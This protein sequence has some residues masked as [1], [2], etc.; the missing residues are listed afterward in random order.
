[1]A[2][3]KTNAKVNN[4]LLK[5]VKDAAGKVKSE[6][7]S[8]LVQK[9]EKQ[10]L[11]KLSKE[12]VSELEQI[13]NQSEDV[14]PEAKNLVKALSQAVN[15]G[16]E[17]VQVIA[18][19][20]ALSD[21]Q[22]GL[23]QGVGTK[24]A[25]N[26]ATQR[27]YQQAVEAGADEAEAKEA[28][29]KAR[30]SILEQVVETA[31]LEEVN[32]I[33]A[34][35]VDFGAAFSAENTES[36][37]LGGQGQQAQQGGSEA[38]EAASA[39]EAEATQSIAPASESEA[40]QAAQQSSQSEAAGPAAAESIQAGEATGG[41]APTAEASSAGTAQAQ[42]SESAGSPVGTEASAPAAGDGQGGGS[43][44]GPAPQ[45]SQVSG[46]NFGGGVDST[47]GAGA[48]AGGLVS[49]GADAPAVVSA[50]AGIDSGFGGGGDDLLSVSDVN[51]L[52]SPV[53][54]SGGGFGDSAAEQAL[55]ASDAG[56]FNS[57]TLGATGSADDPGNSTVSF[58]AGT[59]VVTQSLGGGT[60]GV[61][62]SNL[63][64]SFVAQE[65]SLDGTLGTQENEL[66]Q[67]Q[68]QQEAGDLTQV[69]GG[70][71]EGE[72]P[73]DIVDGTQVVA[74]QTESAEVVFVEIPP[75]S[76]N[77][78]EIQVLEDPSGEFAIFTFEITKGFIGNT[79]S[80]SWSVDGNLPEEIKE[81]L[82]K[83]TV[84]MSATQLT[85]IVE[86]R[87]PA[88][89]MSF[90]EQFTISL[91]AN[92][93]QTFI[94]GDAE[95]TLR[96]FQADAQV[97]IAAQ[98]GIVRETEEGSET[99][100]EFLVTR[101]RMG[102]ET[103]LDWS[104]DDVEGNNLTAEDFVGGEIPSGV[105]TF[106]R[107]LTQDTIRIVVQ[108]DRDVEPDKLL[109][110]NLG[111]PGELIEVLT[112][113]AES[114]IFNDDTDWSIVLTSERSQSEGHSGQTE[115]TFEVHRE[116]FVGE[117]ASVDFE[118]TGVGDVQIQASDIVGGVLPS[119]TLEF[120]ANETVKTITVPIQGD[121][122]IEA[123][124]KF[125]IEIKNVQGSGGQDIVLASQE[126]TVENDDIT[127][128][129]DALSNGV[130]ESRSDTSRIIQWEIS[131]NGSDAAGEVSWALKP[132]N[133]DLS[134]VG[135]V[136]PT[137][138][139]TF[140]AGES[141]KIVSI[142]LQGDE[143]IE[144]DKTYTL[145]LSNPGIN[146]VIDVSA[147]EASN[148]VRNDDIGFN[149]L[150]VKNTEFEG[151]GGE[152]NTLSYK[153]VRSF[154]VDQ[155]GSVDYILEFSGTRTA[156]SLDFGNGQNFDMPSGTV[157]FAAGET[158]K[159]ITINLSGDNTPGPDEAFKIRLLN[160][161]NNGRILI[162]SQDG[163][164]QNDDSLIQFTA[165][166]TSLAE[167]NETVNK[168]VLTFTR[169][170][171]L[172]KAVS[173][174]FQISGTGESLAN[175]TDF[176]SGQFPS[177][178]VSFATGE[179]NKTVEIALGND[180]QYEG[181]EFFKINFSNPV[182]AEVLG[183]G[184]V[185]SVNPDDSVVSISA[186]NAILSEGGTTGKTHQ[187]L[188]SRF[189]N[190]D[191]EITLN[192]TVKAADNSSA[193][194]ADFGGTL[195]S[196]TITLAANEANKVLEITP[197]ADFALEENE[198][199]V[200][201]ITSSHPG[202]SIL[203]S[204]ASGVIMNDESG[205]VI[206]DVSLTSTEGDTGN[207]NFEFKVTRSGSVSG[208]GTV[209]WE[210]IPG[211]TNPVDANDFNGSTLPS[212]T[213]NF[214]Q[215]ELTKT[216]AIAVAGD[217][218]NEA[219]ENFKLVLKNPSTGSVLLTSEVAGVIQNDDVRVS[220]AADQASKLEGQSG[221]TS[222][223]FT[224]TRE[225][226]LTGT[227][228]VNYVVSGNGTNQAEATDFDGNTF[229]SGTVSFAAGETSK[230]I[231]VNISGDST[232][233]NNEGFQVTLN[234]PSVG[235]ELGT[236]VA[237]TTITDDDDQLSLSAQTAT[238]SETDA[239]G[240]TLTYVVN[241]TGPTN[242]VTTVD[243]AVSGNGANPVDGA[244][245]IGGTLPSG[246]LTFNEGETSKTITLNLAGDN[247]VEQNEG[248]K[249]TLSNPS[250]GTS[251]DT[252]ELTGTV[253][254]DDSGLSVAAT[255]TDLVEGSG[256]N[257]N[258]VFTIT[259]S[260][261]LD[262]SNTVDWSLEHQNTDNSDFVATTGQVTFAAGE[263]TKTVNL[264]VVGDTT[265][266]AN[267]DF[268][269]KVNGGTANDQLIQGSV[270]NNTIVSDDAGL[271]IAAVVTS[272]A[273]GKAGDTSQIEFTVTR[274][275]NTTSTASANWA[276]SGDVN[277]ADFGGTLPS[278][279]VSFA[280]G[281]TS[282]TITLS[283]KGDNT[284]ENNER[285]DV[286]LSNPNSGTYIT[287]ATASTTVTN[288]DSQVS[289]SNPTLTVTE[290]NTGTQ[291]L[292]YTV[293]RAG[294]TSK[295][296]TVGWKA[297]ASG[298][299]PVDV[300]DFANGQ[301]GN[302]NNSGLPSGT[303]SFAAGETSKTFSLQVAGENKV[304]E[305]E[306]FQIQFY[307][308]GDNT[309][310]TLAANTVTITNDDPGVSI[311]AVNATKSEGDSGTT[312]V[313]F[314]VIRKGDL[315]Q[316][317][318]VD[319]AVSG[320]VNAADFVGALPSGKLTFAANET[321]KTLELNMQGDTAVE[322]NENLTVT[323]SNA[324]VQGTA[325]QVAVPVATATTSILNEDESFSVSVDQANLAEGNADQKTLTYTVTRSGDTTKAV[326][327]NYAVSSDNGGDN[328][329]VS[330]T[331][332]SG[333]LS[334]AAGETSK[335]V[336]VNVLGDTTV[337]NNENLKL[338]LS[339]PS[340]G[341]LGTAEV[342]SVITND[343]VSFG[344]TANA[345]SA[346]EGHS[347]NTPFTF[348]VTRTGVSTGTG[349]VNYAVAA[350][351]NLTA[352]D[353][354]GNTLPSGTINFADGET[355]KTLTINVS[356]DTA[357]ESNESFVVSL[358]NPSTGTIES[359][360][361]TATSTITS[362]DD[363]VAVSVNSSSITEGQSGTQNLVYTVTRT[364]STSSTS[365]VDY[366]VTGID[367]ADVSAGTNLTGTL[368]FSAGETT[369]TVTIPLKGD[370]TVETDET[371]V[372]TLSNPSTGTGITTATANTVISNDDASFAVTALLADKAEGNSG[373]V[374]YTF[375]ITRSGF[376]SQS[377]TVQ[378]RITGIGSNPANA[379]D[380][381]TTDAL[382]DNGGLPSGTLTFAS[383]E[384]SK[385]LTINV[386]AESVKEQNEDFRVSL[387]NPSSGSVIGTATADGQIDNDDA[388]LN[389]AATTITRAEVDSS[390]TDNFV[391]TVNRT[392]NTSQSSTVNWNLSN[393]TGFSTNTT[394]GDLVNVVADNTVV[395][396]SGTLT[397][398]S[399]QTSKTIT[400]KVRGDN[401]V[402]S[403]EAFN[404]VLSGASA[405]TSLG[406]SSSATG[407]MTNDDTYLDFSSTVSKA[408]GLSGTT[409]FVYTVTRS[410]NLDR[411]T[412][413]NY[414]ITGYDPAGSSEDAASSSD[415][416]GG[417]PSGSVS[418]AA[419]ETTKTI[420]LNV[421]GDATVE[422][423]EWFQFNLSSIVGAENNE[424]NTSS[425]VRG[426]IKR[427]EA[428]LDILD[429]QVTAV[430]NSS[431]L[432]YQNEGD[433]GSTNKVMVFAVK[434]TVSTSGT[435][436]VQWRVTDTGGTAEA[437]ANDFAAGQDSLADNSGLP[438]G[439][440]TFADGE[441]YAYISV[442]VKADDNGEDNETFD[443]T[444]S[445]AS[446]G[447]TI[448]DTLLNQA[449]ILNDDPLF[450]VQ[451]TT[452]YVNEGN[453][454]GT[455]TYTFTA[456]RTGDTKGAATVDWV[457]N[458]P[459]TETT[460]ESLTT[461][462]AWY[463]LE[464]ADFAAGLV[465]SGTL[466]FADGESSKTVTFSVKA[467]ELVESYIESG[468]ITLSN[469]VTGTGSDPV[470]VSQLHPTTT[471]S[472]VD[473]EPD[474]TVVVTAETGQLEGT[475][476]TTNVTFTLTRTDIAGRAGNLTYPSTFY[477][478][479]SINNELDG[480]TSGYITIAAGQTTA[481]LDVGIVEDDDIE[482][483]LNFTMY[484]SETT[485]N[486]GSG[487]AQLVGTDSFS[488]FNVAVN[489]TVVD[490]DIR[491]WASNTSVVE[492][493]TGT[494][495]L[496]FTVTRRGYSGTAVSFNYN[497]D[498]AGSNTTETSDFVTRSGTLTL[499][500]NETSKTFVL[501]T[502]TTNTTKEG[503]ETFEIDLSNP[504][505]GA[506]FHQSSNTTG[507][508]TATFTG[509]IEDDDTPYHVNSTGGSAKAESDTGQTSVFSF[510]ISRDTGGDDDA[511]TI[512]WRVAGNGTHQANAA[513]FSTSDALGDNGGLPS[514]TVSFAAGEYSKTVNIS[515]K[516]DVSAENSEGF[517]MVISN[518]SSG[519][520]GT[521]Q[522]TATIT[523]DDTG[524]SI[525]D[526]TAVTEGNS[527]TK[528]ITF[529]VTRSG[530]LTPT[531]TM[532]YGVT[533]VSTDANDF[534]GS[535]TGS[536]SFS[537]GQS[538]KT[539]TIKAKGD[540]TVENNETFKVTLSSL[541]NVDEAID[542]EAVGTINNDD[543]NFSIAA[544]SAN[545]TENSGT[546]HTFTI[547][548]D[549]DTVQTQTVRWTV[550]GDQVNAADFGGSLP[551]NTVT[552]NPGELTKTVTIN[553]S[554]DTSGESDENFTVTLTDPGTSTGV[555]ISANNTASGKIINDD[556]SAVVAIANTNITEGDANSTFN[557]TV[558]RSG[559][560]S[561]TGS[562]QWKLSEVSGTVN[563]ADF[564]AG[565]D[566]LGANGGLP[567]GTVNW[568]DGEGVKTI[569][570]QIAGDKVVEEAD[571]FRITLSNPTSVDI[572]TS[573]ADATI[574]KEDSSIALVANDSTKAEGDSGTTNLTFTITRTGDLTN[575]AT[576]DYAI[577]PG[578]GVDAADFVGSSIP[579]GTVTLPAGQA[580]TTLTVPISGDVLVEGNETFTVTLSNASA[581]VGISDATEVGTITNEDIDFVVSGPA[582]NNLLEKDTGETTD[583]VF[584][585]TRSGDTSGSQTVNWAAAGNGSN[586][587][588]N[589]ELVS[590][591]DS[592]VF[593]A[594][595]TSKQVTVSVKGDLEGET[596]EGFR[597]SITAPNGTTA[598]TNHAD[599]TVKEDEAVLV[600]AS[601]QT[602]VNEGAVGSL[603]TLTY[604]VTRSG[605]TDSAVSANYAVTTNGLT[606]TE[607]END[608]IPSGT[609]NFASGETSKTITVK[610]KGDSNVETTE[611]LTLT[612]SNPS[613]GAVI[614]TASVST[615]LINDDIDWTVAAAG[616][617]ATIA[618]GD[619][620]TT[621]FTATI[622]RSG[623]V[624]QAASIDY[625]VTPQ[626]A[627]PVVVADFA[628]GA[629]PSG[630]VNFAS[631]ET[632]KTVTFDI[633]TDSIREEDEGFTLT[634]SNPTG[635]G[636]N[637]LATASTNFTI[638]N[639]DDVMSIASSQTNFIEGDSG[640]QEL[641]FTVTRSG[642][643]S[644]NSSVKWRM[645]SSS[646]T[647]SSD[648]NIT[649]GTLNFT[650]GETSKNVTIQV[651]GDLDV[652]A[653]ESYS[654]ELHDPGIGSTVSSSNGSISGQITNQD[655]DLTPSSTNLSVHEGDTTGGTFSFVV[656]RTGDTSGATTVDYKL[657]NSTTTTDDFA[658]GQDA[659]GTNNGLPSGTVSFAAGETAK[660]ISV[661]FSP[662][663]VVEADESY[664]VTLSNPSG[665]A[666]INNGTLNATLKNDDDTLAIA[667]VNASKAEGEA[668][669]VT[670]YEFKVDRGSSSVGEATVN[671]T[672]TGSSE[673]PLDVSRLVAATGTLTFADGESSKVLNI[674]LN[675]D[676]AGAYDQ[677]FTVTLSDPSFGSTI[678]TVS[679]VGTVVN[680]DPVLTVA[681]ANPT[682]VEGDTGGFITYTITRS[683]DSTGTS[684]V[685]F[686]VGGSGENAASEGDFGGEFPSGNITFAPGETT[687][688]IAIPINLDSSG[689]FDE[690]FAFTL[691]GAEGADVLGE[692]AQV[693]L[694]NDDTALAIQSTAVEQF[695]GNGNT[696]EF[697]YTVTR[698]G[699]LT[700]TSTVDWNV[701]GDGTFQVS[702]ND[703]VNDTIPSGSL[704]FAPDETSKTITF[705][706]KTDAI[707]GADEGFKVKLSNASG[708][709]LIAAEA[710]GKIKNDD[711]EIFVS[712]ENAT[713]T[714]GDTESVDYVFK[715]ARTGYLDAA[716]SVD[717][718]LEGYGESH[719][720]AADFRSEGFP[721]G[722]V[723]FAAG[724]SEKLVTVK[725][726]GDEVGENNEQFR[727]VL[728]S[729]SENAV[730][731]ESAAWVAATITNDDQGVFFSGEDQRQDEGTTENQAFTFQLHR[732]GNTNEAVTVDWAV[733][734]TGDKAASADDFVSTSG[735]LSFAAGE[736]T[737][738]LTIHSKAD[739]TVE[740]DEH[741]KVVLT[742]EGVNFPVS[743]VV[744]V[745]LDDDTGISVQAV[746]DTVQEDSGT[747]SFEIS[748]TG[749]TTE[750]LDVNYAVTGSGKSPIETN[751]LTTQVA[752]NGS[753]TF[754][755]GES[756]KTVTLNINDDSL[757]EQAEAIQMKISN[758]SGVRVLGETATVTLNDNDSAGDGND[759][760]Y[761]DAD[762]QT[763][764]GGAGNDTIVSEGGSDTL[765]G[766]AGN[767]TFVFNSPNE[768]VD[769]I[770]DFVKGQDKIKY[771]AAA[772]QN[773]Q[774]QA[775]ANQTE[776]T[777]L[778]TA[779]NSLAAKADSD[780]YT[781]DTSANQFSHE[782]GSNGHL[783]ELEAAFTNGEHTGAAFIAVSDGSATQLYFDADTNAGT[784]GTGLVHVAEVQNLTDANDIDTT[785]FE[786]SGN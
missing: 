204:Q 438:S 338:T 254:N 7:A 248:L 6:A 668:G 148:L 593:A 271:A 183:D 471:V 232:K 447:T 140:A 541:T 199:Y 736:L 582:T 358:S 753:V 167:G 669:E 210:L 641:T 467:D 656:T 433:A 567:S 740:E 37:L 351:G 175:A 400:V 457:L 688:T 507:S 727:M 501:S 565:Q 260:G 521:S 235:V 188:V 536:L 24:Q 4:N 428:N 258:H 135:G 556:A 130:V 280:A 569:S 163:T 689:E 355:T 353:F 38:A 418:F 772:F 162:D 763:L 251:L 75:T 671:W 628:G 178:S 266:E 15:N 750:S 219:N 744:G 332:P 157:Q 97:S 62:N 192:Y 324:V 230:S 672:V 720:D 99:V 314:N 604:T 597:F 731:K 533:H 739:N 756:T 468:T 734:G 152:L 757:V 783:D 401:T 664:T 632:S 408:E 479:R 322:A 14:Q 449:Q 583:F 645:A 27:A 601:S 419:G 746:T 434:R 581:N 566:A 472:V 420:T 590:T 494:T 655:I 124:E 416:V 631:G 571:T 107:G 330:G 310:T 21:F 390:Q 657:A 381:S 92:D 436:T 491:L 754:A 275:G 594:G 559:N 461:T 774:I 439:T 520:I 81:N 23:Q 16:V 279:T 392:G 524:I 136:L 225:G 101:D 574:L 532:N 61:N 111:N 620:S 201:E 128:R 775:I 343:D 367:A 527:G 766:G 647:D 470:F 356:G 397:F 383:G 52:I 211:D 478:N 427:D 607:F 303:L 508:T 340:E 506:L 399:G 239:A 481:T 184:T 670:N 591:A 611:S 45:S 66:G 215:G 229:P 185:F 713:Q 182:G 112:P 708:A 104:L 331:L 686:N 679:A 36:N 335:T 683:G 216:L 47:T 290:G 49:N 187:F 291:T 543:S 83:D 738:Q 748:R 76:V 663:G 246:T 65:V 621:T 51:E 257:S 710:T 519:K 460:N 730:I 426:E 221:N 26:K 769:Y 584:T 589:G 8:K 394:S 297:V 159:I 288:D 363:R 28:A 5:A 762:A 375:T 752:H 263:T 34:S 59:R 630:T 557:F 168:F 435:T 440:L 704:T 205:L 91:E 665:N 147:K 346:L 690:S 114:T 313:T 610:V 612:L 265:V 378:Y 17:P 684:S 282:K 311:S 599:A 336:V 451:N 398:S 576:V 579:S 350:N 25:V 95:K 489:A 13:L 312:K 41:S 318:E 87:I 723:Q 30:E 364:E 369:K 113:S 413:F 781:L 518:P 63:V 227:D 475:G 126:L 259:R 359:T 261:K 482:S 286:N 459:G 389:F 334:F 626:G 207:K 454:N 2:E 387:S 158:E 681:T 768:G 348:T 742:N 564:V 377:N 701:V 682:I 234:N 444:L 226:D 19:Q 70:V 72:V 273:E 575:A 98:Q 587:L 245:F 342:T 238:V 176:Q 441:E 272:K 395:G 109:K 751:D 667:A 156:D 242:T 193:D 432:A 388:E 89:L 153:V 289:L 349:S 517:K 526:A 639:D 691:Q 243:Y 404:L 724:E 529:T 180:S 317:V 285:I 561:G 602:S 276:V 53:G 302:G 513:D 33:R 487:P 674:Q 784:D 743:E 299:N 172:Q 146:S 295:A 473:D 212:G 370:T 615:N 283:L 492:G 119:G 577:T 505:A 79:S 776:L 371:A 614:N 341:V 514:G 409:P 376:T 144:G 442:T 658:T 281:E 629:F 308:G 609:V 94:G 120:A 711:S 685:Q 231:T 138:T 417:F 421:K 100:F 697:Q 588:S 424:T 165:A 379:A 515:V 488:D 558:T 580:N 44:A 31:G 596:D 624:D 715:V 422:D 345:A 22:Q 747:V 321:K 269:F 134:D 680:D 504:T 325:T 548:R 486:T 523:T 425:G 560:T 552:F 528:D 525:S 712:I 725:V 765:I 758:T 653:N 627:N 284:L 700:G 407:T 634:I 633:A 43:Q 58:E 149:L 352:A 164:I 423:D 84:N 166:Q 603:T 77:V 737:K 770:T 675:G 585:I 540:A 360:K 255:T 728:G 693:T 502:V 637:N 448:S 103:T 722:T 339:S 206:S 102:G 511:A 39:S 329:D 705:Q 403:N 132:G 396:T 56:T 380:F 538:S 108:G 760:I 344:I 373:N 252:S 93:A 386:A 224:V 503:D 240:A 256:T 262:T 654:I 618:E 374:P 498:V 450:K 619:S 50:P 237:A 304:E 586:P 82:P 145:E 209:Q 430:G 264:A 203:N 698:T 337:E 771:E 186:Q 512:Q 562:V 452:D 499:N 316:I 660:T 202:V 662:D 412:S 546:A 141:S 142:S 270:A 535:L 78:G 578:T 129:I 465:K 554:S 595:E 46:S 319:Y 761:G 60:T 719:A 179:S 200:V 323:L 197:S 250:T 510:T 608:T 208:T 458:N 196:G 57:V 361:A 365:T 327:V 306:T 462:S 764:N 278:G 741:F 636:T 20:T 287:N 779:I 650:D 222:F 362:D 268:I 453:G 74:E 648:F 446:A 151:N 673:H 500:A 160:A 161:G 42:G 9:I 54:D 143:L 116:G 29:L 118:V 384:T 696:T 405:G 474:P 553:S 73:V 368:T 150:P 122:L 431:Y 617:G 733:Q 131:R 652:E 509:T 253:N 484:F 531:T 298:T 406:S 300:N 635:S 718:R 476:G 477:W 347:G 55:G 437:D 354:A 190:T 516:G 294:D 274:S 218:L 366:A 67:L 117:A 35:Q 96:G 71:G 292:T 767:D 326:T 154:N 88:E 181:V 18:E 530:D 333:T 702:A 244:D 293:A 598:T 11:A 542:V 86:I 194:A 357:L 191:S 522:A 496:S 642:S 778:Q 106:G 785:V 189:G 534:D 195:P 115:F 123:T 40:T 32:D 694:I 391:F 483:D 651:L 309:D 64:G 709:D 649:S 721:F 233:E 241:R 139:A 228:T 666:Q 133:F 402:E 125:Q 127:F 623:K 105:V 411:T 497:I 678:Q 382:G 745:L 659:L 717:W 692:P 544:T 732:Y 606:N 749:P 780:V 759:I 393:N 485:A 372:F 572:V 429:H 223:T 277:A 570:I 455:T 786:V 214:D 173:T 267:E 247:N 699:P 155:A 315:N 537:A 3:Q 415:F 539:I 625:A 198:N 605:N 169:T 726:F 456:L 622:T 638:Q 613:T 48:Q 213:I 644:G 677:G 301:D 640:H 777:D 687:K 170:G 661:N 545:Q 550:S 547:T 714:E 568:A 480:S 171:N 782:A 493:D 555:I 121:G 220:I 735:T 174:D 410:G 296:T 10:G 646:Q 592:V 69:S 249:L 1:M 85:A 12:E 320:E 217:S 466:S 414:N 643:T 773:L 600:V 68:N 177:G 385:T 755:A 443:I 729:P 137:G 676:E 563:A 463:K 703:F 80:I 573:T 706:A 464:D 328:N 551:T 495:D 695:E 716:A 110:V 490:D 549:K 90:D 445:N 616:S 707:P 305:D 469:G 236:A 307:N